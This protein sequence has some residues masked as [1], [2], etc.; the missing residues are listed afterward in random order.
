MPHVKAH[1]LRTGLRGLAQPVQPGA[2]QRGGLHLGR[3]NAARRAHEGVNAQARRPIARCL[4]AKV[5][6]PAAD[7]IRAAAEPAHKR[8]QRLGMRQVQPAAP[9]QQKLAPGRGHG[10]EHIHRHARAA[11]HLGGHQAR[12]PGADDGDG[13]KKGG[14]RGGQVHAPAIKRSGDC[15]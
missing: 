1:G 10:V 15:G 13:G 3:K 9:G 7:L 8:I 6:Q 4:R 12:G 11:E 5:L 14:S 2:Q